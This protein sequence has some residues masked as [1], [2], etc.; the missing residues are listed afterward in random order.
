MNENDYL[1]D[2]MKR[3]LGGEPDKP[4]EKDDKK[5]KP[6]DDFRILE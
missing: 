6:N 5:E 3:I 4:K 1:S 2:N